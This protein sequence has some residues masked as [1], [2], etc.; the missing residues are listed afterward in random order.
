[1]GSLRISLTAPRDRPPTFLCYPVVG[2]APAVRCEPQIAEPA[3]T[4]GISAVNS[5]STEPSSS[6]QKIMG[7]RVRYFHSRSQATT[8]SLRRR[9]DPSAHPKPWTRYVSSTERSLRWV[10]S[11][12]CPLTGSWFGYD[13]RKAED[14]RLARRAIHRCRSSARTAEVSTTKTSTLG[15]SARILSLL[16]RLFV[17]SLTFDPDH[18]CCCGETGRLGEPLVDSALC[19]R[20]SHR[21]GSALPQCAG[22]RQNGRWRFA[23]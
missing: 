10:M 19:R 4:A 23:R 11:K 13:G 15:L 7:Q 8:G 22:C 2:A 17:S 18:A 20:A 16:A 3:I 14:P 1:M 12:L 5:N 21:Y 6:G 9:D